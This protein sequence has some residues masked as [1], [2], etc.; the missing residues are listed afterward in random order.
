MLPR[1]QLHCVTRN[2]ILK[3]FLAGCCLRGP[4]IWQNGT[5]SAHIP[6]NPLGTATS[7]LGVYE[8][9]VDVDV[10]WTWYDVGN[11]SVRLFPRF[12]LGAYLLSIGAVFR[13]RDQS[14]LACGG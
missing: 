6:N 14:W 7:A 3:N 5:A 1:P 8:V 2:D 10:W 9:E 11:R 12:N 4:I 13:I